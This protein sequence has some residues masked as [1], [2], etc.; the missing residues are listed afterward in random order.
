MQAKLVP[1]N[2]E[3]IRNFM[4]EEFLFGWRLLLQP[5]CPLL[6]FKKTYI[7]LVDKKYFLC[8]VGKSGSGSQS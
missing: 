3:K 2:G 7:T 1:K 5:E 6:W 8:P 4:F